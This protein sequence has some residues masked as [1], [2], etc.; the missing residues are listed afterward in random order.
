[1]MK[2]KSC[3][4]LTKICYLFAQPYVCENDEIGDILQKEKDKKK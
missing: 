1:M 3:S 2:L 4:I